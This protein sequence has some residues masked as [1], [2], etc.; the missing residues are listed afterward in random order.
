MTPP[1]CSPV[2]LDDVVAAG[3]VTA[4]A[5]AARQAVNLS[6]PIANTP[7]S[8]TRPSTPESIPTPSPAPR[9]RGYDRIAG[10]LAFWLTSVPINDRQCRASPRQAAGAGAQ[11][12][13]TAWSRA[14]RGALASLIPQ[15]EVT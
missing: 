15:Q 12:A 7:P 5:P 13:L 4:S 8:P 6:A 14:D 9:T 11:H 3:A 10:A 2:N 1:P